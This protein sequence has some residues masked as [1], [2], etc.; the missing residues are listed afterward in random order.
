VGPFTSIGE[1]VVLRNA[2][3]EYAVVGARTV[4]EGVGPRIQASLIGEDVQIVG[5]HGRPSTHRLI[6]G[7]ESRIHLQE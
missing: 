6:V 2:E 1:D 3:L 5:H 7:D 4:I